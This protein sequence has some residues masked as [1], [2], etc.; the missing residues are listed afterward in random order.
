MDI[1]EHHIIVSIHF[2]SNRS[3]FSLLLHAMHPS[4]N[5]SRQPA[6]EMNSTTFKCVSPFRSARRCPMS[7]KFTK[8][9]ARAICWLSSFSPHCRRSSHRRCRVGIDTIYMF[10][11]FCGWRERLNS[12]KIVHL[13]WFIMLHLLHFTS[14]RQR[15]RNWFNSARISIQ[16]I[17]A[18]TACIT[19][20][21]HDKCCLNMQRIN[22]WALSWTWIY[23]FINSSWKICIPCFAPT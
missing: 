13:F 22:M 5:N 6:G 18:L 20:S 23:I 7:M 4:N 9:T 11:V 10:Q 15:V 19:Y 14:P 8:H 21:R 2:C 17:V 12:T 1:S 3:N 16:F